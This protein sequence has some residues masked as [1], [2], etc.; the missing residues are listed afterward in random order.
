[1]FSANPQFARGMGLK[2]LTP[3]QARMSASRAGS[4]AR[5]TARSLV[6]SASGIGEVFVGANQPAKTPVAGKKADVL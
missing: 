1:M 2:K 6:P 5:A 3:S 4:A